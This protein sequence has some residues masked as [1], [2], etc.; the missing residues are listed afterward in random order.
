MKLKEN[1]LR[2]EVKDNLRWKNNVW[3]QNLPPQNVPL[4]HEDYFKLIIFKKQKTQEVFLFT[5]PL[6]AQRI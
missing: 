4:W 5:S 3:E 2:F 6:A 1:A